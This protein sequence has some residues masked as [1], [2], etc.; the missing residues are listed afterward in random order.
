MI[1][2]HIYDYG[3]AS[4]FIISYQDS[5]PQWVER[6]DVIEIFP[7]KIGSY[8]FP[9][10]HK[11]R[12]KH[13]CFDIIDKYKNNRDYSRQNSHSG[14]LTHYLDQEDLVPSLLDYP[15]FETFNSWIK[16]CSIDYIHNTL[17]YNCDNVVIAQCWIN[18]CSKGGSQQSHVHP[19]SFISGTYYVNF[20]PEIHAPLTFSKPIIRGTPHLKLDGGE[21]VAHIKPYEGNLLLWES[22]NPH[23]YQSNNTDKRISISFNVI[24]ETLPGI[25]GFKLIKR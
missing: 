7:V 10:K 22:H 16:R 23:E 12:L 18:D 8:N 17:G 9:C 4:P 21:R 14:Y 20:I 11:T 6:S 25:Y 15:G 5:D 19:N 1:N 24:P 3:M 2:S 13:L